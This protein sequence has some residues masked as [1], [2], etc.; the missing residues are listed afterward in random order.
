[1]SAEL[2]IAWIVQLSQVQSS[3]RHITTQPVREKEGER[4]N[5]LDW[6]KCS[7]KCLLS[8]RNN[9]SEFFSCGNFDIGIFVK[10]TCPWGKE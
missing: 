7:A 6:K 8:G 4:K 9:S 10:R 2:I 3:Q 5:V 1:M